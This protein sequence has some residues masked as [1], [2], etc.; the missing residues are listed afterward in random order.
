V[1]LKIERPVDTPAE[2]YHFWHG[3]W[4]EILGRDHR[5]A[6]LAAG[7]AG[8][9]FTERVPDAPGGAGSFSYAFAEDGSVGFMDGEGEAVAEYD[10]YELGLRMLGDASFDAEKQI[11]MGSFRIISQPDHWRTLMSLLPLLRRACHEAIEDA[12]TAFE[13]DLPKYW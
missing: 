13:L 6:I 4:C 5:D 3:R 9:S 11:E 7:L 8:T 2:A 12:E 10:S 1:A